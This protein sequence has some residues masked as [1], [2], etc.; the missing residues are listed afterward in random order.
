MNPRWTRLGALA[1]L[2]LMAAAC[3]Q[4]PL[5]AEVL[6][7]EPSAASL[8]LVGSFDAERR[9]L[10]SRLGEAG[11]LH[12]GPYVE[13]EPAQFTAEVELDAEGPEG[14]ALG[15]VD[16]NEA[17]EAVPQNVLASAPFRAGRRQR[18]DLDFAAKRGAKYEFRVR[19]DGTGN[20]TLTKI[21]IV[22]R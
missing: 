15:A 12:Y 20:V 21:A 1:G 7:I 19:S 18:I 16:V 5:D 2:L 3:R 9:A 8:H 14:V 13:L 10:A 17:T 6:V 4:R 11:Y 22:R